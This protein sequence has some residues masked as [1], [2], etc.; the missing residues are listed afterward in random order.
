MV[1]KSLG[2]GLRQLMQK[3]FVF[4]PE[5]HLPSAATI[6]YTHHCP[7]LLFT[8]SQKQKTIATTISITLSSK[9]CV[10]MFQNLRGE[11]MLKGTKHAVFNQGEH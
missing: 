9:R 3:F 5:G 4:V 2:H 1:S 8:V 10:F 11:T 7:D 6:S